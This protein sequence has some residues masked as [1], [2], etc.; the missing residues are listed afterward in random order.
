MLVTRA[1][2]KG[3]P[4]AIVVE[5][6]VAGVRVL[7]L[8]RY[9]VQAT[10]HA[11]R[12]APTGH[13]LRRVGVLRIVKLVAVLCIVKFVGVLC[14]VKHNVMMDVLT[15]MMTVAADDV[16]TVVMTMAVTAIALNHLS[17]PGLQAKGHMCALSLHTAA[18]AMTDEAPR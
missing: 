3:P 8:H 5:I 12:L 4:S 14:T 18:G 1:T 2:T 17:R 16:L 9:P 6:A 11:H 15:C 10:T 13:A 7:G